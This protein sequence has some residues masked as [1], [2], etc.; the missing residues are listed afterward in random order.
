MAIITTIISIVATVVVGWYTFQLTESRKAEALIERE[1][2]V[3]SELVSLIEQNVING[4]P[5]E[6]IRLSRI[7]EAKKKEEDIEREFSPVEL[8]KVSELNLLTSNHL[9][10]EQKEVYKTLYDS[11]YGGFIASEDFLVTDTLIINNPD[12][13]SNLIREINN[14]QN[15]EA[16]SSL[17]LLL[18][19]Y[20][21]EIERLRTI[22]EVNNISK[23]PFSDIFKYT[24]I[25]PFM[26]VYFF[27]FWFIGRGR[28]YFD[29]ETRNYYKVRRLLMILM[30]ITLVAS[31]VPIFLST[32]GN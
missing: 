1:I 30:I 20:N 22:R 11:I 8:I 25:L 18:S 24:S 32:L 27:N 28:K 31:F 16:T 12:L 7:I 5:L 29:P 9:S 2:K 14:G 10:S 6:T 15:N 21:S 13:V 3:K 19:T 17:R 26:V 4:T 23:N